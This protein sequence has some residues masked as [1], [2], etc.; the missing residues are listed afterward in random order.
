MSART[1]KKFCLE[2]REINIKVTGL[3]VWFVRWPENISVP[4]S[5]SFS[6]ATYYLTDKR[7]DGSVVVSD[8]DAEKERGR[9]KGDGFICLV[10]PILN[11]V[12]TFRSIF[13][14]SVMESG[15][16]TL[17]WPQYGLASL[18]VA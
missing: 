9:R 7:P 16:G 5:Q 2:R 8:A 13:Q 11:K 4:F 6:H 12:H 18:D 10:C 1:E 3:F 15:P 14:E 17:V